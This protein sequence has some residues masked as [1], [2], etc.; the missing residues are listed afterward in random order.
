MQSEDRIYDAF[1]DEIC[2]IRKKIEKVTD[3]NDARR[4][5]RRIRELKSLQ[6][7]QLGPDKRETLQKL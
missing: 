4:L 1:A 3:S 5:F 7:W 6:F 2:E